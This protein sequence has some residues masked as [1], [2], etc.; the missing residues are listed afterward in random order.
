[1]TIE[2]IY[3]KYKIP[4]NLQEH[5]LRVAAVGQII[6][7]NLK[8]NM[9][10]D[11]ELLIKTLLLHDMGNILK[12]D[13]SKTNFLSEPDKKR[14]RK[15]KEAQKKMRKK[16]GNDTDKVTVLIIQ[17]ITSDKRI[18][19]LCTNSHGQHA[20]DFI[21]TEEW[22]RKI[23]YYADMRIGPFGVLSVSK[24]FDDL[25]ERNQS[26]KILLEQYRQECLEIEKQ[27]Q[28]RTSIDLNQITD[29]MVN[30]T[31][32]ELKKTQIN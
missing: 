1:M 14:I 28:E 4:I 17:E 21:N 10:I 13:F 19:D 24:R 2:E 12:F 22:E 8:S 9:D 29:V 31:I 18:S 20:K 30:N 11:K 32:K 3:E 25:I 23:S 16:Y 26:K 6:C 7:K 27:L 15:F 5:M